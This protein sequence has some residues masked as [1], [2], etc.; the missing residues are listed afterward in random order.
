MIISKKICPQ[1]NEYLESKKEDLK[2]NG[3]YCNKTRFDDESKK[4][5]TYN[6]ELGSGAF[7]T[8]YYNENDNKYVLK[9]STVFK[10]KCSSKNVVGTSKLFQ[11]YDNEINSLKIFGRYNYIF[12]HNIIKIYQPIDCIG[13][14]E[15]V[16]HRMLVMEKISPF[17]KFYE[18]FKDE[19]VENDKNLKDFDDILT[20]IIY[21]LLFINSDGIFHYDMTLENIALTKLD[22]PIDLEYNGLVYNDKNVKTKL[23]DVTYIVKIIDFSL[24]HYVD[25]DYALNVHDYEFEKRGC[26]NIR[27][28]D[29]FSD[30]KTKY[31]LPM[32]LLIL[33]AKILQNSEI[34]MWVK[35]MFVKKIVSEFGKTFENILS[36]MIE[37]DVTTMDLYNTSLSEFE[38]HKK[39]YENIIKKNLLDKSTET[40]NFKNDIVFELLKWDFEKIE[41]ISEDDPRCKSQSGGSNNRYYQKYVKYKSKYLKYKNSLIK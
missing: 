2:K 21:V 22:K 39:K 41:L 38:N 13:E 36:S 28:R 32:D 6:K 31:L 9:D 25:T 15:N 19:F 16:L 35:N 34:V 23:K 24:A 8:V 30:P 18:L 40:N 17:I 7:G 11:I 14:K 10:E 4:C 5:Y 29:I 26:Y 3:N 27:N 33:S 12:P 20:Q 1:I 37:L